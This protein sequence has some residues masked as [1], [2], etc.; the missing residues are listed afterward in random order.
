MTR[1]R[2]SLTLTLVAFFV[3]PSSALPCASHGTSIFSNNYGIRVTLQNLGTGNIGNAMSLWNG[4][5]GMA[6]VGNWPQFG[7]EPTYTGALTVRLIPGH[8]AAAN[9]GGQYCRGEWNPAAST[10]TIYE[11]AGDP[12]NPANWNNLA[13]SQRD[14]LLAHELGH[15]LGLHDDSCFS[16]IMNQT[17]SP[18]AGIHPEEC[19]A[20]D[21][22][23]HVD[24]EG[25]EYE[26]CES[27]A[28]CRMSPVLLDLGGDGMQLTGI[29]EGVAFDLDGDGRPEQ[30][31]WT[32]AG[33][34]EAFLW[35]DM[36]GNGIADNGTEL[37][38]SAV[39]ANGF[40]PLA[41]FDQVDGPEV[42]W[43][44]NGDGVLDARDRMW[45][46]L[47]LWTDINHDGVCTTDEVSELA[48]SSVSAI[49]LDYSWSGRRDRHDNEYRYRV[50]VQLERN[51]N[52]TTSTAYDVFFNV[53]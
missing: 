19:E 24:L 16:G 22:A 44:G 27:Y 40:E 5:C 26:G 48:A 30:S 53:R 9:C 49:G 20:A 42:L 14:A 13:D 41:Q 37:F 3:L 31:G 36:N 1:P 6:G 35:L 33:S 50:H 45:P 47:R 23:S 39:A 18:V 32:A 10:I 28:D 25:T 43:G 29:A 15:V 7:F 34:D 8:A 11:L 2:H 38:G 17:V 51:G 46:R 21:E 52:R 12:N 4:A